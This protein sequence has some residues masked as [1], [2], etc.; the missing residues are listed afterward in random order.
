MLVGSR[1]KL[2]QLVKILEI[3]MGDRSKRRLFKSKSTGVIIDDVCLWSAHVDHITKKD[4][5]SYHW[6][7][8][9]TTVRSMFSFKY[10]IHKCLI[11]PQFDYYGVVWGNLSN[12]LAQSSQPL[13]NQSAR[14]ITQSDY[15]VHSHDILA[16]LCWHDL[17]TR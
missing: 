13:Q 1:Y 12:S 17:A 10:P 16:S 2:G 14:I 6:Y 7:E 3:R 8:T 4:K 5:E 15:N 9:N 11:E